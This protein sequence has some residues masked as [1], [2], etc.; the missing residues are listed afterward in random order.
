MFELKTH[1]VAKGSQ[2]MFTIPYDL[3]EL[4]QEKNQ[5]CYF[6]NKNVSYHK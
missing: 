3:L 2:N 4:D 6:D 1:E 5:P